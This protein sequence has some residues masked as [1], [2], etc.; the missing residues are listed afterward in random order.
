[1]SNAAHL[2]CRHPEPTSGTQALT[3][4][5]MGLWT[6]DPP[7]GYVGLQGIDEA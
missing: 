7:S 1:M 4:R 6:V 2:W 5:A 3:A